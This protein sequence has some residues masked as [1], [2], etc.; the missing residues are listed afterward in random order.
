MRRLT[1]HKNL[2]TLFRTRTTK[3]A[4]TIASSSFVQK[5]RF[6]FGTDL[7]SQSQEQQQQLE[8][9]RYTLPEHVATIQQDIG[10]ENFLSARNTLESMEEFLESQWTCVESR[11]EEVENTYWKMYTARQLAGVYHEMRM[12]DAAMR[13]CD[14]V[15][16]MEKDCK[17]LGM[18]EEAFCELNFVCAVKAEI[19]AG[20]GDFDRALKYQNFLIEGRLRKRLSKPMYD[21]NFRLMLKKTLSLELATRGKIHFAMGQMEEALADFTESLQMNSIDASTL[22]MKAKVYMVRS[23]YSLALQDARRCL[24]ISSNI[25]MKKQASMLIDQ[26][27]LAQG[28]YNNSDM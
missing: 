13:Q 3:N 26:C 8:I 2:F 22:L 7:V 23:E 1:S 12:E 11:E 5:R 16:A 18:L 9:S 14:R 20:Q 10:S 25:L 6:S 28:V 27:L 17:R 4:T 19:Y 21:S 24:S 15:L